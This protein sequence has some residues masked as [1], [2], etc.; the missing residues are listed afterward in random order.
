MSNIRVL[1][2]ED[3]QRWQ[4]AISFALKG[5]SEDVRGATNYE[6]AVEAVKEDPVDLVIV[7]LGL[8]A[9]SKVSEM[10]GMDLLKEI[11]D[12]AHNQHC[13]VI[14]IT[15]HTTAK[16]LTIA[17]DEYGVFT[18]I[19]KHDFPQEADGLATIA[20]SAILDS[21]KPAL[22]A[23]LCH[24]VSDKPRV[25][26]L[27]KRLRDDGFKPWFDEEDL[28]PG[29]KWKIEIRR[30]VMNSDVIIVCLSCD[31]VNKTGFV[32]HEI[33]FALDEADKKPPDT[34]FI[35]PAKLEECEVP[36][37]LSEW[38]WV[39]LYNDGGYDLLVKALKKVRANGESI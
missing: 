23:F 13:A 37:R 29:H 18:V 11:R 24:A 8:P 19:D 39:N 17:R 31:S 10:P 25:R 12:S 9:A 16:G 28:L 32:Q 26:D 21:H 7:D 1:V 20:R 22:T 5:L 2:V 6:E 38:H 15:G 33:K 35:I 36:E 4:E 34:I 27:Y 3:N 14:I 30:A